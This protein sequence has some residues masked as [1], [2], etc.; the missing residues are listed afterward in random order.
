[1]QKGVYFGEL[2]IDEQILVE[3][4]LL[5]FLGEVKQD[6]LDAFGQV[7]QLHVEELALVLRL[8]PEDL[9]NQQSGGDDFFEVEHLLGLRLALLD[10]LF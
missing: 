1:M 10:L 2:L 8:D 7:Q 4:R 3:D 6:E 9:G 5:L